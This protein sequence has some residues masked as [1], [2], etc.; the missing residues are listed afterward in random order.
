VPEAALPEMTNVRIERRIDIPAPLLI[1]ALGE[2]LRSI[3]SQQGPWKD[4]SFHIDL[5][6]AGLPDVGYIAIPIALGV[7]PKSSEANQFPLTISAA[8]HADSFPHFDGA[9]GVDASGTSGAALWIGGEYGVP[10]KTVGAFVDSTL[11]RGFAQ[12]TLEN[13]ADDLVRAC[14]A[15]IDKQEADYV[16]YHFV[17]RASSN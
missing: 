8:H 17:A 5:A 11:L 16:R 7:G 3:A 1:S 14:R 12:R 6:D 13:F 2:I 9:A 4:F 10:A 15:H